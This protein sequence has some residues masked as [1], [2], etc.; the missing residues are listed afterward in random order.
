MDSSVPQIENNKRSEPSKDGYAYFYD[1]QCKAD[2]IINLKDGAKMHAH[3]IV[4]SAGSNVFKQMFCESTAFKE[5]GGAPLNMESEDPELVRSF[6]RLLYTLPPSASMKMEDVTASLANDVDNLFDIYALARRYEANEILCYC[7]HYIATTLDTQCASLHKNLQSRT[8]TKPPTANVPVK[9]APTKNDKQPA[10]IPYSICKSNI[11]NICN[12]VLEHFAPFFTDDLAIYHGYSNAVKYGSPEYNR[13]IADIIKTT[14]AMTQSTAYLYIRATI[15]GNFF[16][17]YHKPNK[18]TN[19]NNN[20]NTTTTTTTVIAPKFT[21][22]IEELSKQFNTTY[23]TED[24]LWILVAFY[25]TQVLSPRTPASTKKSGKSTEN[26]SAETEEDE[27]NFQLFSNIV[28]ALYNG[29]KEDLTIVMPTKEGESTAAAKSIAS[30]STLVMR[31]IATSSTYRNHVIYGLLITL[32]RYI[33]N[34]HKRK[35]WTLDENDHKEEKDKIFSIVDMLD[36]SHMPDSIKDVVNS[37]FDTAISAEKNSSNN[38]N[39]NSNDNK[40]VR[41]SK[42]F[43]YKGFIMRIASGLTSSPVKK[44][45]TPTTGTSSNILVIPTQQDAQRTDDKVPPKKRPIKK[46]LPVPKNNNKQRVVKKA[47]VDDSLL[48][49][50]SSESDWDDDDDDIVEPEE[51]SWEWTTE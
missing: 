35:E 31:Y 19:N 46:P 20:N 48:V 50:S 21:D 3:T 43:W 8:N 45:K 6:I 22:K 26:K 41:V 5:S 13:M 36:W 40:K 14:P 10:V 17:A 44:K 47:K 23:I 33:E 32:L 2:L 29:P 24:N 18:N 4:L 9:K 1:N 27:R 11:L 28:M 16:H 34:K 42:A 51:D 37:Y 7:I 12:L 49:F 30:G 39:N 15:L 38:N 25:A